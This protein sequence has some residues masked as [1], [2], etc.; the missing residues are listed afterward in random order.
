MT[1]DWF[2]V[3]SNSS[4]KVVSGKNYSKVGIIQIMHCW[5]VNFFLPQTLLHR[6]ISSKVKP[7]FIDIKMAIG[8]GGVHQYV[9]QSNFMYE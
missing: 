6:Y 1:S 8:L 2:L 3:L 9:R 7:W 4:L 5:F